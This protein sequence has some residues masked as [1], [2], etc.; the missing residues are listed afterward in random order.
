MLVDG[1]KEKPGVGEVARNP[2]RRPQAG[3]LAIVER[4]PELNWLA[5]EIR[6]VNTLTVITE[7]FSND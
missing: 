5:L 2:Q 7:L 1:D 4:V 3:L 6:L